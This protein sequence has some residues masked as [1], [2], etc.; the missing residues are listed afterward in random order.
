MMTRERSITLLIAL[1]AALGACGDAPSDDDRQW[2]TKAP[3]E[4]PGLTI[5]A[6]EP[7]EMSELG[8]P[9][10]A[11]T[12]VGSICFQSGN[13]IPRKTAQTANNRNK[14]GLLKGAFTSAISAYNRFHLTIS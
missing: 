1:L 7:S 12:G 2:Y 6:E 11:G 3:L 9:D 4:D 13:L 5:T 10:L 8:A 14:L